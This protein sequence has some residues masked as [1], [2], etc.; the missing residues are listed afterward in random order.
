MSEGYRPNAGVADRQRLNIVKV[1]QKAEGCI[2]RWAIKDSRIYFE[3]EL[4]FFVDKQLK[5]LGNLRSLRLIAAY[6]NDAGLSAIPKLDIHNK[7]A[8][9]VKFI[10]GRDFKIYRQVNLTWSDS[11]L[12][13]YYFLIGCGSVDQWHQMLIR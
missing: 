2:D 9:L 7:G 13:E 4:I 1:T 6:T 12:G 5:I 11:Y 3:T 8:F 10:A